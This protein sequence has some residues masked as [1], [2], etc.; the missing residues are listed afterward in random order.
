MARGTFHQL[1]A[2]WLRC[3]LTEAQAGPK[4]YRVSPD[5]QSLRV[6]A[7]GGTVNARH[8]E[9][10]LNEVLGRSDGT[11]GQTRTLLHASRLTRDPARDCLL[12]DPPGGEVEQWREVADFAD[13]HAADRHFTLDSLDGTLTFGPAL[14]QPDGSVYQFGATPPRGSLLR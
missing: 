1:S 10:V 8:A 9:T 13:S 11:P 6:E 12:I 5:V 3:R 7:R 2:Y 4:S 14:L